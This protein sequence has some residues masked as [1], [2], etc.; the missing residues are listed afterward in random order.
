MVEM[1]QTL[2]QKFLLAHL[3]QKLGNIQ[4]LQHCQNEWN[5][6]YRLWALNEANEFDNLDSL[7]FWCLF[8]NTLILGW[9]F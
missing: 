6:E 5:V 4:K 3:L 8:Q 9:I 2:E 7:D 1:T